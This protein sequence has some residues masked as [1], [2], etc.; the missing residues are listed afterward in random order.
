[1]KIALINGSPKAGKN[2]SQY[3]S[4]ELEKL[5]LSAEIVSLRIN[6][7]QIGEQHQD[8]LASCDTLVFCFPLYVDA[9]PSQ[10]LAVLVELEVF[11]RAEQVTPTVYAVV[12]CGFYEGSQTHIAL[13]VL[14]NWAER[15]G[16]SW[17]RGMGIGGGE[18]LGQLGGVP[19]GKGPKASLGKALNTLAANILHNEGGENLYLNPDFPRFAFLWMA[20]LGW[21]RQAKANGV[22]KKDIYIKP[23]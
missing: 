6:R 22:S 20:A 18:M 9:I 3:F 23:V 13:D 4:D 15:T 2:N 17:G 19:L 21:K 16:L 8:V 7:P 1:M 5:L 10:L 11:L 12:N 14:R